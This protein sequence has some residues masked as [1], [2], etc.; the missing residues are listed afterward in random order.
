VEGLDYDQTFAPIVKFAS[1]R[2]VLAIAA[3]RNWEIHQMDVKAAYLNS[4]LEEEI[5]MHPP[6]GFDIPEGMV[7]KLIK[8]VYG[9][10]Q[11][12]RVWYEDI[13]QT[14]REMGY[15]RIE[16]DH[17][18]FVRHLNST[19]SIIILYV[20]DITMLGNNLDVILQD[21]KALQQRYQMT[22]LGEIS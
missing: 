18:V 14:L 20:D 22:D 16:A 11:G 1:F 15:E 4:K 12:G 21:K 3:E 6:P 2:T 17:A 5:F 10:K 8:A 13:R 9:T 19:L 7:L